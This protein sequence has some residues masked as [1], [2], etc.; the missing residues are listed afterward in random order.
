[1]PVA[2]I[3]LVL[4]HARHLPLSSC[5][6]A[7]SLPNPMDQC[8]VDIGMAI[9]CTTRRECANCCCTWAPTI[10]GAHD[11]LQVMIVML[12]VSAAQQDIVHSTTRFAARWNVPD[13]AGKP[14]GRCGSKR[15]Q[16]TTTDCD[17]KQTAI[18][19]ACRLCF[20]TLSGGSAAFVFPPCGQCGT[21]FPKTRTRLL[22]HDSLYEASPLLPSPPLRQLPC[23]DGPSRFFPL[24]SVHKK[25]RLLGLNHGPP[26]PHA[27]ALPIALA[28]L[29]QNSSAATH[30]LRPPPP[31]P[32]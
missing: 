22:L 30:Y 23:R 12:P 18:R 6:C 15:R 2:R 24:T 16:W 10:V 13:T 26:E 8:D 25:C 21:K 29:C 3:V 4:L 20:S 31:H 7:D 9:N 1:M 5:A 17:P 14:C 19:H 32:P 28:I 27:N 11:M